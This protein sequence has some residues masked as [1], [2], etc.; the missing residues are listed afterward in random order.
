MSFGNIHGQFYDL[1]DMLRQ[2]GFNNDTL[3]LFLGDYEDIG[4]FGLEIYLFLLILKINY[5]NTPKIQS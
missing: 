3:L 4:M 1:V 5:P 2:F